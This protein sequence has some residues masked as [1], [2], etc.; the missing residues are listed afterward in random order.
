MAEKPVE[1]LDETE[2]AAELERLAREIATHDRAYYG[3]DAPTLSDADYDVLRR[4]NNAIEARFPDLVRD[5]SPSKRVG[6]A[7]STT[8]AKVRHAVPMLSLDNAFTEEDVADFAKRVR[9]MA[10]LKETD[11][12]GI[13]AE[14]KIDGLSLSLR[15]VDGELETAATRGDG[16]VGED[17]TAN[18]RT[19]DDIPARI[20]GAPVIFEVR[21]EVYMAHADFAALNE[22]QEAA[23]KPRFANPRNA[24]AGSLR[25]KDAEV[26]RA[27]PLRFFAYAW[28]EVSEVPGETQ[29]DV[30]AAIGKFGFPVNDLMQRFET[31]DGL[32]EHYRHIEENRASLG[33]DIDGVVYKVDELALQE[34]LGFVS[35]F[36][37]WAIAHKF[38]AEKAMTVLNGIDVTTGRTG[39]LNPI[40]RLEPVTVGGVVVS[41]ATLHNEDYIAGIDADGET[42]RPSGLDIRIGDTVV[43]QRAGDVIP[44]IVD[45]VAEK[46]PADAEP[47]VFPTTCAVCGSNAVRELNPRTGRP[48]SKRHCTAGL[49]CPAQG[50]EGLKHLVSRSAFDIDGLGDTLVEA[51]F[52]AGLVRQPADIF[53]LDFEKTK[54]LLEERALAARREREAAE[55]REPKA[56]N[57]ERSYDYTK[58]TQN[59]F[60]A[61]DAR[62]TLPLE[63][64]IFGLGIPNVGETTAKALARHFS[65]VAALIE[66]VHAAAKGK[67][68]PRWMQLSALKGIGDKSFRQL[69]DLDA[70]KL[71]DDTYDPTRDPAAG[72]N[73]TRRKSLKERYGD[74]ASIRAAILEAKR[75]APVEAYLRLTTDSDIGTVATGSLINFFAEEHNRQAVDALIASGVSTTNERMA[76]P[77]AE[78]SPVSGLI[79]V[80]TGA[81]EKMTRDEAKEMAEALGAKTSGSVSKKTD[82]VVA[83]PGAGSKLSKASELGIRVIDEEGWF[84]LIGREPPK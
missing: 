82:L 74:A 19:L 46:R 25:Q 9:R 67:P 83:G 73:V 81:L 34:E 49:T 4:R 71:E 24:A 59:L 7:P 45:V 43:I 50:R 64:F 27:R 23:G 15:Y 17:V 70:A 31:I 37:R 32:I 72:L 28:G 77:A 57:E 11:R 62:R 16:T 56:R 10:K 79:V 6:T 69:L 68:G 47:Y 21:G 80:F 48:E 33:Y 42:I 26:T 5:D 60:D 41:N 39:A 12:L 30:V 2:A 40:A 76:T 78:G 61:I 54:L 29:T 1:E 65:D 75:T 53:T 66:G 13:T 63:R 18:A 58:T 35:R 44:Q 8:F 22:R 14:P 51:M 20:E 3:E 52:D 36:P 55:G 84:E 38:A